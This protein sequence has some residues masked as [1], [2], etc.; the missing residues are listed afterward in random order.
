MMH[1][2]APRGCKFGQADQI[3]LLII[4]QPSCYLKLCCSGGKKGLLLKYQKRS[5]VECEAQLQFS[6]IQLFSLLKSDNVQGYE[7]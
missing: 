5:N 7:P 3:A 1:M 6:F 4:L 2:P